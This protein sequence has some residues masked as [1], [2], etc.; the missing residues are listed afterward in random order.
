ME[1]LISCFRNLPLESKIRGI[2]LVLGVVLIA[3]ASDT[4]YG[5]FREAPFLGVVAVGFA[6]GG[7]GVLWELLIVR[8]FISTQ[9]S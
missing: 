3:L 1:Q 8:K 4:I 2:G 9:A 6:G 5:F 7:F